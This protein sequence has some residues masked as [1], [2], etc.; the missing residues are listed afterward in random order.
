MIEAVDQQLA[1]HV[2]RMT[3]EVKWNAVGFG[4][5]ITGSTIFL[6]GK[7]FGTD[8]QSSIVTA[9]GLIQVKNIETDGLL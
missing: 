8:V 2:F 3:C 9:V 7:A 4:V 5:P 6:T 1:R